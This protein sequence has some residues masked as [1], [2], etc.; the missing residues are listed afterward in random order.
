[1]ARHQEESGQSPRSIASLREIETILTQRH[2]QETCSQKGTCQK[3]RSEKAA[4]F[5][6]EASASQKTGS[7]QKSH[8]A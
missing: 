3:T 2:G 5:Q 1:M 7:C 6:K 8:S 4:A